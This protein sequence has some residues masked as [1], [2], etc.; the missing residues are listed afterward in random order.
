MGQTKAR[1]SILVYVA[2][3]REDSEDV[4]I[5]AGTFLIY[6]VLYFA[7][8]DIGLTHSYI[9]SIMSANSDMLVENT[10]RNIF[11][12]SLLGQSA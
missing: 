11:V 7:L 5:I 12:I 2:R 8:I 3:R 4:V 1:Q 10:V 9:T 6:F